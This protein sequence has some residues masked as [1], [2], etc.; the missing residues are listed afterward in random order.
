MSKLKFLG[1]L[2]AFLIFSGIFNESEALVYQMAGGPSGG[3]F[4]IYSKGIAKLAKNNRLGLKSNSSGG[5][6]DNIQKVETGRVGF[7]IA[8]SGHVYEAIN[9]KLKD[10]SKKFEN[11][12]VIG[13]LYGAPAQLGVKAESKINSVKQINKFK[14]SIGNKGSGAAA[15]GEL[16]FKEMGIWD[17]NEFVYYGYKQSIRNF[18]KDKIDAFWLFTGFP[19][20]SV[21]KAANKKDI[22]LINTYL[23]AEAA[24]YFKKYP[25]FSKVIIPA[26]TYKNVSQDTITFQ[27]SAL[28]I[29]NKTIPA[30]VVYSLTKIIY[31]DEGLHELAK[32]HKAAKKLSIND[33]TNGIIT[34]FHP[35]AVKYFKEKGIMK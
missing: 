32:V 27:D 21:K 6:I 28:F 17:K 31:C 30:E 11:I 14:I 13:Y 23:D 25:Y 16:F 29:V 8:Y 18:I 22:V 24:G 33:A 5:S 7:G 3:T 19:N 10:D 34:P 12:M 4:I 35:G 1:F 20:P 2:F 9:G 15:T 26:N